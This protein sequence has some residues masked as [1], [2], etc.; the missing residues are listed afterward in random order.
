MGNATADQEPGQKD[1][2]EHMVKMLVSG[3][4]SPTLEGKRTPAGA[5]AGECGRAG[6]RLW[7]YQ[8]LDNWDTVNSKLTQ[9]VTTRNQECCFCGIYSWKRQ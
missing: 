5:D 4:V 7:L 1:P 8:K 9:G 6:G 3:R 2:H